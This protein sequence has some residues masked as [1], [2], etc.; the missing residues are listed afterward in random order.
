MALSCCK[1]LSA[2]VRGI[3]LKHDRD[4]YCLN[5]FHSYAAEDELKKHKD[6]WENY[7]YCYIEMPKEEKIFKKRS[8]RKVYE[9]FTY[10]FC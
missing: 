8:R 10:Y 4:F 5:F 7:D 9:P 3:T 6:V 2:L 1:K